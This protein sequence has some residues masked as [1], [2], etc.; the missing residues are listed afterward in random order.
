[1]AS[2]LSPIIYISVSLRP[3]DDISTTAQNTRYSTTIY[4]EFY[5]LVGLHTSL[6]PR[7]G[8]NMQYACVRIVEGFGGCIRNKVRNH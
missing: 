6:Q 7:V 3:M 5:T 4:R 8:Y 2:R 1:M